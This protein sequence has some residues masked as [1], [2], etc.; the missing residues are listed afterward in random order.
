MLLSGG[1]AVLLVFVIATAILITGEAT[2]QPLPAPADAPTGQSFGRYTFTF[3]GGFNRDGTPAEQTGILEIDTDAGTACVMSQ[4]LGATGAHL[5]PG[6]AGESITLFEPPRRYEPELCARDLPTGP[7]HAVITDPESFTIEF[8]N[9]ASELTL[10]SQLEPHGS[11]LA[12][13][14]QPPSRLAKGEGGFPLPH[15][16]EAARDGSLDIVFPDGTTAR[17]SYPPGLDIS[18]LRAFPRP[19]GGPEGAMIRPLIFYGGVPFTLEGPVRCIETDEGEQVPVWDSKQGELI[20]LEF[21]RWHVILLDRQADLELWADSLRGEVT[22]DGWLI[23]RGND[24]LRIG[25]ENDPGDATLMFADRTRILNLWVLDCEDRRKRD[26]ADQIGERSIAYCLEEVDI[27]VH[28]Q[29]PKA[30][31]QDTFE[32]LSVENANPVFPLDMYELVP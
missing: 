4:V 20:V 27:E 16:T 32:G 30:F 31:V 18:D 12:C 24:S 8:H 5:H 11:M 28:V 23:L 7:L 3:G 14:A 25:P 1:T 10:A 19:A 9:E 15:Q 21:W 22:E 29:G 13:P 17:L 2:E 6:E 26:S